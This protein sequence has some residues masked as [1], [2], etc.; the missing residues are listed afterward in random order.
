MTGCIFAQAC[1]H[2]GIDFKRVPSENL[3]YS[4]KLKEHINLLYLSWTNGDIIDLSTGNKISDSLGANNLK[5][6]YPQIVF[7]NIVL[8][9]GF[10]SGLKAGAIKESISKVFG[11]TSVTSV[12]YLDETAVF[13][14]F[15]KAEMV[16]EF[17]HL[18]ET[19]EKSDG[20]ISVLHPLAKILE[21]GN[22]RAASY[23]TYKEI[24]S[25]SISRILFA[26]QA[27]ACGIKWK[28]KLVEP[29][30]AL[31]SQEDASFSKENSIRS[32]TK[33]ASKTEPGIMDNLDENS[34]CDRVSDDKI[35]HSLCVAEDT[36]LRTSN[37]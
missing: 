3:A 7:E 25:S 22:T 6:R 12:Y 32:A 15:M 30:P 1:S 13:V 24:C 5:K 26:D 8:L 27:E 31:D 28:T 33:S 11:P 16:S 21:G 9:W 23:E 17:L 18:K 29:E 2:L 37:L 36:Q 19:L 20:P 35:I 14:Q 34:F 10:P 4:E